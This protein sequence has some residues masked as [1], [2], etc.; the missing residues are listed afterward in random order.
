MSEHRMLLAHALALALLCASC[1]QILNATA[2]TADNACQAA[3]KAAS[4]AT[5]IRQAPFCGID[6]IAED[7]SVDRVLPSPGAGGNP[8]GLAWELP[9]DL[10][11]AARYLRLSFDRISAPSAGYK[12]QV[13]DEQQGRILASYPASAFAAE[14]A[15]VTGLL[16]PNPLLVQLVAEESGAGRHVKFR[17]HKLLVGPLDSGFV[18]QSGVPQWHPVGGLASAAPERLA[19]EA[20]VLLHIG[21]ADATCTGFLVGPSLIMTAGHCLVFSNSFADTAQNGAGQCADIDVEFDYLSAANP[22][23]ITDAPCRAVKGS[24]DTLDYATLVIDPAP[25]AIGGAPRHVL[26]ERPTG[27]GTPTDI[28]ILHHPAGLELQV[29]HCQ[30]R[31]NDGSDGILHDC[32]TLRGSS[33]APVLDKDMRW[34]GIHLWGPYP[35]SWTFEQQAADIK[36]HGLKFNEARLGSVV[37]GF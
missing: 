36:A 18:P 25:A 24:S 15:F 13:F 37:P 34:V 11:G 21:P 30:N 31:G 33:G 1:L 5:E 12:L 10:P 35:D 29:E 20:V 27:E 19:A 26:S 6:T 4:G 16:R 23:S 17:L 32:F 9:I 8:P 14:S 22:D 7:V 28:E 3:K 2:Q